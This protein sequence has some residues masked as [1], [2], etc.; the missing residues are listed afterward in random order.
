MK[1]KFSFAQILLIASILGALVGYF[2]GE[3]IN[4]I[5]PAGDLFTRLLFMLVPGLVFFSIASSFANISDARKL[6]KWAGKIVGWFLMTTFIGTI[7]GVATGLIWKPGAGLAIKGKEAAEATKLT[8]ATF[9]DWIPKNALG[10]IAEGNIIQIVIFALIA[11]LAVVF[12]KDGKEKKVL[13]DILNAGLTLFIT[14]AKYVLWYAPIGVFALMATSVASFRGSLLAEMANFLTAYT[15]AFV[16]HVVLVYFALFWMVTKLNPFTFTKK[17]FPAL[18]TAFTTCSSAA[19]MPVTLRCTKDVGV[20]DELADFGIPLGVTFNMDS[21]A[22]EI[23]LYIML[24]MYAIGS[25]PTILQLFQFVLL[26]IVF[27]IG[28]AGVPG[29]GLAIATILV[30]AFNLPVEVVAWIAAVFAYL[31]ITGTAMNVWGDMIATTIAAKTEGMFDMDKF[32]DRDIGKLE[33]A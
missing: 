32:N 5:K 11:G 29:G 22:L 6:S 16:L 2:A 4:I 12:L 8:A 9:L 17:V 31:D 15:V 14:I 28:C 10:A 33:N 21:M 25:Q 3:S 26:G 24:G 13:Q 1:K 19:T 30:Q 27:S 7:L 20:S 23:P 18:I